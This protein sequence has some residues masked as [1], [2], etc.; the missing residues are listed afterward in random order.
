M[1]LAV[2]LNHQAERIL[3]GTVHTIAYKQL[4]SELVSA[5]ASVGLSQA[6]LARRIGKPASYVGKY[7]LGERRLDVIELLVILTALEVDHNTFICKLRPNLP[8]ML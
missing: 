4:L 7:E 8:A 2:P 6:Q 5:R 3:A 1:G